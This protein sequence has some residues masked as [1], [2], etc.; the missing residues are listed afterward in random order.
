[1]SFWGWDTTPPK[2]TSGCT[3]VNNGTK[4]TWC[5]VCDKT[6]IMVGIDWKEENK[7]EESTTNPQSSSDLIP[8]DLSP[9]Y[10]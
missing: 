7:R 10:R 9:F 4:R 8:G 2:C 3:L 5:K 1:M 6:Y